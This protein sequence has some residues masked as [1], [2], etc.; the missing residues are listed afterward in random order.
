MTVS[1][2]VVKYRARAEK[3][4]YSNRDVLYRVIRLECILNEVVLNASIPIKEREYLVSGIRN[5]I[6]GIVN[7]EAE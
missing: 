5:V 6:K 2:Q 3:L 7:K 1:N 4:Y